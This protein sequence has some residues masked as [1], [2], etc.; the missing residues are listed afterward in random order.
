MRP[1]DL[2][3]AK[4]VAKIS[5][6]S[7]TA[8]GKKSVAGRSTGLDYSSARNRARS[9]RSRG[10]RGGRGHVAQTPFP[11]SLVCQRASG[12]PAVCGDECL[13]TGF[14]ER[15]EVFRGGS[16]L[17][18]EGMRRTEDPAELQ[19]KRTVKRCSMPRRRSPQHGKEGVDGSSPSEGSGIKEI[20]ANRLGL[21]SQ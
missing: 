7:N 13:G 8:G 2:T 20:P 6:V 3:M 14:G 15:F 18:D 5:V 19:G 10:C 12:E 17:F 4:T 9:G 1:Q 21:L 16:G 11:G